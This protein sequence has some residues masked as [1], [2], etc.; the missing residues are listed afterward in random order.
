MKSMRAIRNRMKSIKQTGKICKAMKLTAAAKLRSAQSAVL[1]GRPYSNQLV[2]ILYELNQ[3]VNF[4]MEDIDVPVMEI[5]PVKTVLMLIATSDKGLC[6]GFNKLVIRKA[7]ERIDELAAL[8]IKTK[9]ILVGDKGRRHYQSSF[10]IDTYG[11]SIVET[12][13]LGTRPDFSQAQQLKDIIVDMFNK[14]EV[15]KVELVYTKFVNMMSSEPVIQTM[16]PFSEKGEVCDIEGN[17]IDIFDDELFT[18]TTSA[19]ELDVKTEKIPGDALKKEAEA[20]SVA[21]GDVRF[22]TAPWLILETI[23]ELYLTSQILRALQESFGS[24]LS[25]RLLAMTSASD[26]AENIYNEV[27][28]DYNK[29][30]QTKITMELLLLGTIKMVVDEQ[31]DGG[32]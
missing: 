3:R 21:D 8:N 24:E 16:L 29:L 7:Q 4:P 11:D 23:I 27:K 32:L 9:L 1:E 30:R 28:R 25:A 14:R 18:L 31:A 2:K 6:G 10:R 22:D 17:C 26:N 5:R 12:A 15:D 20:E 13:K 19:G